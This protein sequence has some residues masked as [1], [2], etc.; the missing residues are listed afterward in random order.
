[1]TV[2]VRLNGPGTLELWVAVE[3][4]P[5]VKQIVE[6]LEVMNDLLPKGKHGHATS[7]G[8]AS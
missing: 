4:D 1:M 7:D 5:L 2:H 8:M 3:D 6:D